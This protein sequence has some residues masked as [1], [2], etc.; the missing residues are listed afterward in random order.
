[1]TG[2]EK[3]KVTCTM[4]NSDLGIITIFPG[5]RVDYKESVGIDSARRRTD[6]HWGFQCAFC[7]HYSL[8]AK[9]EVKFILQ[10]SRVNDLTRKH[11]QNVIAKR[12]TLSMKT[13]KGKYV[14]GFIM[15]QV[16]G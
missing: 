8:A 13:A 3:Y 4:C 10:N 5:D 12:D 9:N 14:D 16:N 7:N 11:L 2:I 1:M 6:G 15:E